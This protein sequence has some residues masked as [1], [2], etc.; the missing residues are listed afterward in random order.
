MIDSADILTGTISQGYLQFIN[1]PVVI[2]FVHQ[3]VFGNEFRDAIV[4]NVNGLYYSAIINEGILKELGG[5]AERIGDA[6]LHLKKSL[7]EA[8]KITTALP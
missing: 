3:L 1:E 8:I 5:S 2:N 4:I 7:H 6:P